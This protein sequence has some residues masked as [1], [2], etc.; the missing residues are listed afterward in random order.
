M[1]EYRNIANSY[2]LFTSPFLT[3]VRKEVA[4]LVNNSE[5]RRVLDICC[6]TGTQLRMLNTSCIEAHGVDLSPAMLQKAREKSP[7]AI[8]YHLEDASHLHFCDNTFGCAII[9]FALHEKDPDIR[10]AILSEAIRVLEPGGPLYV[11]DFLA[12]DTP[13]QQVGLRMISLVEMAAGKSHYANF[14]SFIREGGM[15]RI[16]ETSGFVPKEISRY[17]FQTTGLYQ[18]F[19]H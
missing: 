1:D 13:L 17:M 7:P 14:R 16:L 19:N 15:R 2:D 9:S 8:S 3:P 11:V 6:G 4:R 5:C 10:Q 12:P 18:V